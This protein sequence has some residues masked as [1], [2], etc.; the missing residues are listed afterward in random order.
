MGSFVRS[1]VCSFV[2]SSVG[3]LGPSRGVALGP[4]WG[5]LGW[6]RGGLGD[7]DVNTKFCVCLEHFFFERISIFHQVDPN[8]VA[9]WLQAVCLIVAARVVI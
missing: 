1:L 8:S 6:S 7:F 5:R 2:R 3:Y 9:F 4:A